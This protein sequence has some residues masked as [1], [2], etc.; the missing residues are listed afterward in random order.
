M[1]KKGKL[2]VA[3]TDH[4]ATCSALNIR[5]YLTYYRHECVL[6]FDCSLP[7]KP[8]KTPFLI[9]VNVYR[10]WLLLKAIHLFHKLSAVKIAFYV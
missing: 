9:K 4:K 2:V 7:L 8:A 10:M 5:C 6:F 1:V 3:F